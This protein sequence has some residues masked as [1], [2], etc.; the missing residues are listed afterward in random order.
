MRKKWIPLTDTEMVAAGFRKTELGGWTLV[1]PEPP[2]PEEAEI[3]ERLW[4]T[5]M[6]HSQDTGRRNIHSRSSDDGIVGE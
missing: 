1:D 4:L 2:T 5:P 3:L 6:G